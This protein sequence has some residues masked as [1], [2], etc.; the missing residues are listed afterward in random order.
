M[1]MSAMAFPGLGPPLAAAALAADILPHSVAP[2]LVLMCIGFI[3]GAYG[4]VARFRWLVVIGI[5]LI[6]LATLIFPLAVVLTNPEPPPP[7]PEAPFT[8]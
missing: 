1:I 6:F 2:Y 5:L 3:L 7:G 4:H 8:P